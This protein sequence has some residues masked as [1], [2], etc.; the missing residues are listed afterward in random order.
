[1]S[2]LWMEYSL[3]KYQLF[4][5]L[6]SIMLMINGLMLPDQLSYQHYICGDAGSALMASSMLND[7]ETPWLDFNYTYGF[8]TLWLNQIWF[9]C[10]GCSPLVSGS[11]HILCSILI[12]WGVAD[13]IVL[14]KWSKPISCLVL[15]CTPYLFCF[16]WHTT[17]HVLEPAL[18]I[19]CIARYLN[20]SYSSALIF[21]TLALL[22][23]PSLAYF[24]G[25][26]LVIAMLTNR[27]GAS[28]GQHLK[29]FV[30]NITPSLLV[31]LAYSA[32]VLPR[33]G[34]H[35][36]VNS[37]VPLSGISNYREVSF[38]IFGRG[39]LFWL[40][41]TDNPGQWLEHYLLTPAGIWLAGTLLLTCFTITTA[42][43]WMKKRNL[44]IHQRCILICGSLHLAF[45]FV[46][47]GHEWSWAYAPYLIIFGVAA[48]LSLTPRLPRM[49]LP[50][51]AIMML[52]SISTTISGMIASWQT[53]TI[54]TDMHYLMLSDDMHRELS[55]LRA[56]ALKN[57]VLML[58]RQGAPSLLLAGIEG[59]PT[60]DYMKESGTDHERFAMQQ[61][62]DQADMVVIPNPY[63]SWVELTT[64]WPEIADHLKRFTVQ[65]RT[66]YHYYF[67]NERLR[68][69][70][71][72][73][74]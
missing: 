68:G 30:V 63:L 45:I 47:F 57:R 21:A 10:F 52:L 42:I 59:I 1:M 18:L 73:S 72:S 61:L 3:K 48:S 11:L 60:W 14:M 13:L 56:L 9:N 65:R 12:C 34:W 4:A 36:Y 28:L 53:T 8:G 67:T 23:K 40:P 46:L 5:I 54:R 17:T 66:D 62:I 19:L 32:Y 64:S 43:Q 51:F 55:Q 38:G 6:V 69:L 31:L 39:K 7:G 74:R 71:P 37:L 26:Y 44:S 20:R 49:V 25:L 24:A 29:R 22:V 70:I 16:P 50:V 58:T 27:D 2:N 41:S 35:V 33:W 15:I